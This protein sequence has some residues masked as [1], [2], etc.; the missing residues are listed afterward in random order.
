[1][2]HS[3]P[4]VR[5]TSEPDN[6]IYDAFNKA[7]GRARGRWLYFLGADDCLLPD[8]ATLAL[9]LTA[10]E[11]VHYASVRFAPSGLTYGGP[12]RGWRLLRENIPHQVMIY[13]RRSIVDAGGFDTRFSTCYRAGV[14]A[15]QG[16]L[17]DHLIRHRAVRRNTRQGV[18]KETPRVPGSYYN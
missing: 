8:F 18:P 9:S 13:S 2:S 11:Q 17:Y 14:I 6:G 3:H 4:G 1:M 12:F 16:I 10:A 15:T 5:V 7:L